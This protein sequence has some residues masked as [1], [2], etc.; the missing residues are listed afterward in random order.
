MALRTLT[1]KDVPQTLVMAI[2]DMAL[3]EDRTPRAQAERL[4]REALTQHGRWPYVDPLRG[5]TPTSQQPDDQ[6]LA[7]ESER[8]SQP[9]PSQP[10][11]RQQKNPRRLAVESAP[12]RGPRTTT[13]PGKGEALACSAYWLAA[14]AH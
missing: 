5:E 6:A 9:S 14:T 2:V 12:N 7:T 13:H 1:L 8:T 11:P 4:L 3:A 10:E